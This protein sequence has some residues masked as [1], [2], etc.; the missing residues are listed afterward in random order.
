MSSAIFYPFPYVRATS[1]ALAASHK[2]KTWKSL[3]CVVK[4][5]GFRVKGLVEEQNSHHLTA[6]V[7][8]GWRLWNQVLLVVPDCIPV[9]ANLLPKNPTN[10]TGSLSSVNGCKI[11]QIKLRNDFLRSFLTW[12]YLLRKGAV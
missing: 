11:K 3:T 9:T 2:S 12:C 1:P 5:E 10:H 7:R 4:A 8:T 6:L